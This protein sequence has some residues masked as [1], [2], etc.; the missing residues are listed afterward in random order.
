MIKIKYCTILGAIYI[1]EPIKANRAERR[2]S[3]NR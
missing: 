2:K 1:F 3:K